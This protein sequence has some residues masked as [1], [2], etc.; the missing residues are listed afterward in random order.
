MREESGLSPLVSII[1]PNFNG[2]EFLEKC[3]KSVLSSDY[4]DFE[5]LLVDDASTDDSLEVVE[6]FRNPQLRVIRNSQRLGAAASRNRAVKEAGGQYLVFLDN[7]TEVEPDWLTEITKIFQSDSSIGGVQCKLIDFSDREQI[8]LAGVYL[9]P[10]TLWGIARGQGEKDSKRW[11]DGEE[12]T[13]ISAALA[14]KRE[15]L[16]K[17][18]G[19]DEKLSVYTEDLDFS[20]RVWLAGYR[21]VLAPH[22]VVYHWTKPVEMRRGMRASKAEIYFH[23]CKNSLRSILKNYETKNVLKYLPCSLAVNLGRAFYVLLRR[24]D[25]SA[26]TGTIEGI[27]WTIVN[28]RDTLRKRREIQATRKLS[29]E[30]VMQRIMVK[31]S[32]F[33]IY[34]KYF[35]KG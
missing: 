4:A 29:D 25:L 1:I 11:K 21:I 34:T 31:E 3:L 15:V 5:V 10:H 7:D 19:F 20:L 17:V 28:I 13:A 12:V 18:G 23:L 2:K 27:F 9:I 30:V 35:S 6:L 32:L 24:G 26:L 16:D 22:S 8:Q 14:I 33:S